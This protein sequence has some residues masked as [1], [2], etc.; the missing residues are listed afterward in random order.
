MVLGLLFHVLLMLLISGVAVS[1]LVIL[2]SATVRDVVKFEVT[3]RERPEQG[4]EQGVLQTQT[5][6]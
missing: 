2:R 6:A 3:T 1:R 4:V 5:I